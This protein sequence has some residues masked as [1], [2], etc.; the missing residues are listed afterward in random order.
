M[1]G[2]AS[3]GSKALYV[4]AGRPP[5]LHAGRAPLDRGQPRRVSRSRGGGTRAPRRSQRSGDRAARSQG[6]R[7]LVGRQC[8]RGL[9]RDHESPD[10]RARC[11]AAVAR[12]AGARRPGARL[13]AGRDG[14]AL[15]ARP[16]SLQ[17]LQPLRGRHERRR[18]DR[19]RGDAPGDAPGAGRPRR[20]QRG[21][22]RARGRED[23]AHARAG[24]GRRRRSDRPHRRRSD[25]DLP[26]RTRRATTRSRAPASIA[27]AT[28]RAARRCFGSGHGRAL[29]RHADGPPCTSPY[30]DFTPLLAQ[31][32][33]PAETRAGETAT[34]KA[35]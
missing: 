30:H 17:P 13:R 29:L 19:L 1:P 25:R 10:A 21:S 11:D 14:R 34:R 31:L 3:C 2:I 15:G 12:P 33:T 32:G 27:V 9:R 6:R 20:R 7:H 24:R 22:E 18:G 28:G 16:R 35:S 26:H 4:Y 5:P 8:A 23:P